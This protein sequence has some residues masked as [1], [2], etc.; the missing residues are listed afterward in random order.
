VTTNQPAGVPVHVVTAAS[1]P[2]LMN[3]TKVFVET[4][5]LAACAI[6]SMNN[7]WCW[8][9]NN[10]GELGN[11][12]TTNSSV[13]VPVLT[14]AG[15]SQFTGADQVALALDHACAHKTDGTLWCWGSN[16]YGQIGVGTTTSSYPYPTQVSALFNNVVSVTAGSITGSVRNASTTCAVTTDGTAWCWGGNASGQLGNGTSTGQATSPSHVL[17][18]MGGQAFAGVADIILLSQDA[19]GIGTCLVK[20]SDRSLWCWGAAATA[21][22]PTQD[23]YMA[24]PVAHVFALGSAVAYPFYIGGDG[25]TYFGGPNN[26]ITQASTGTEVVMCP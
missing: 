5:G 6:D 4:T 8:G 15:G 19:S 10:G 13:A 14:Q 24:A 1:G 11:G 16:S 23:T 9:Y 20:G 26:V 25:N 7:V 22:I 3:I 2:A 18:S 21:N 17:V 12:L